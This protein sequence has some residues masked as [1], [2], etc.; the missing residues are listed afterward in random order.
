[1]EYT[2]IKKSSEKSDNS[3]KNFCFACG[4]FQGGIKPDPKP[5]KG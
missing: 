5:V 3:E 1:M 2:V 4:C